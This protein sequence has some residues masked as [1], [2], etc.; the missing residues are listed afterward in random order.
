MSENTVS[1]KN[2]KHNVHPKENT[3]MDEVKVFSDKD[4]RGESIL[5]KFIQKLVFKFMMSGGKV[6][7]ES[8]K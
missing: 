3:D 1:A 8:G 6:D 4:L 2:D 5:Y 7:D